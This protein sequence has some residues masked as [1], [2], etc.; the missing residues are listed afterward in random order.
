MLKV[1]KK[2]P[3]RYNM[4][5]WCHQKELNT[6]CS[7]F[8][9]MCFVQGEASKNLLHALTIELIQI[10]LASTPICSKSTF[11][12]QN[13]FQFSFTS[14]SKMADA[15]P[16]KPWGK[17]DKWQQPSSPP[18]FPAAIIM[19]ERYFKGRWAASWVRASRR[20]V[21][22]A[23]PRWQS[24]CPQHFCH[25]DMK[26]EKC[27]EGGQGLKEF[28]VVMMTTTMVATVAA[29]ATVGWYANEQD[30]DDTVTTG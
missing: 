13:L 27:H 14:H 7:Y 23:R 2:C 20:A 21:S 28:E 22:S 19:H 25:R 10:L 24:H 17:Q 11:L 3:T 30:S 16:A 8:F 9:G 12:S 26:Q 5:H 15:P 1:G 4:F 29:L 6:I 18:L